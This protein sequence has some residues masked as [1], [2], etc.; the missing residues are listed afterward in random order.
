MGKLRIISYGSEPF[1]DRVEAGRLLARL[2]EATGAERRV[3]IEVAGE[4]RTAGALSAIVPCLTDPDP[5]VRATALSAL[6]SLG[7]AAQAADLAAVVAKPATP[8]EREEAT[9]A[10]VALQDT[11][12]TPPPT[13]SIGPS[14]DYSQPGNSQYLPGLT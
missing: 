6:G 12:G 8:G 13:P 3:L 9:K 10:L 4:R 11:I 5:A 14:L 7:E 1:S 2:K